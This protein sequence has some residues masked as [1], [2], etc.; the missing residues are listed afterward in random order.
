MNKYAYKYENLYEGRKEEFGRECFKALPFL[1]NP[2]FSKT[3]SWAFGKNM[4][5]PILLKYLFSSKRKW[6]QEM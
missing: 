2:N 3:F 5:F 1:S 6:K 4:I